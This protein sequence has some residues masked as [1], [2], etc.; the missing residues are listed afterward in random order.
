VQSGLWHAHGERIGELCLPRDTLVYL[1]ERRLLGT[2]GFDVPVVGMGTWKTFDVREPH[3]IARRRVVVDVALEHGSNLFDSSPMYG[4]AE[5]VLG[6]ALAGRREQALVATKVWTPDDAEAERQI[7][8]ALGYFGGVVDVYQVHNLVA[9][10]RR[11]SKLERLQHDGLVRAI[12]ATHY[13]H[14]AFPELMDIMRSGRISCVQVPYNALD[15]VVEERLL[16]LAAE[17]NVG[18]IVMR[19]L[20]AGALAARSPAPEQLRPLAAFG[21]VTW[22]QVLLKWLLSDPRVT[23]VIP[24]T[25]SPEHARQNAEAG[26]PP[27]FGSEERAY[28]VRL[29]REL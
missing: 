19:P 28:V 7:E 18:V 9:W 27:W 22:S 29:A 16:P 10:R 8:R 4:A 11:L 2:A 20:G 6:A 15:R 21:V 26:S 17:L 5:Q 1:M 25:T 12:G 3:A 24:A 14:A 13:Q 23:T